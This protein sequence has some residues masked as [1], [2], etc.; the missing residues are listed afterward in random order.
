MNPK[1]PDTVNSEYFFCEQTNEIMVR[2][3]HRTYRI[4]NASSC[5]TGRPTFKYV[6]ARE[7]VGSE[8]PIT[9]AEI[10]SDYTCGR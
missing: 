8:S 5:K 4:K 3:R 1:A 10:R 6:A 7:N 9:K 2:E